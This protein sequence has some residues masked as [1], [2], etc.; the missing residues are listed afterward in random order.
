MISFNGTCD[1]SKDNTK[2][3][4]AGSAKATTKG[5]KVYSPRLLFVVVRQAGNH[6]ATQHR[7]TKRARLEKTRGTSTTQLTP[8][9]NLKAVVRRYVLRPGRDISIN[10]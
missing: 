1:V 4:I 2:N 6:T 9:Q 3:E 7:T 8:M 10:K 5:P